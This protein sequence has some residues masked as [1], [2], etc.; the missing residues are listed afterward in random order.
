[1]LHGLLFN[2]SSPPHTILLLLSSTYFFFLPAQLSTAQQ[3]KKKKKRKK[4]FG[5]ARWMTTIHPIG[6]G[7]I[8]FK[9]SDSSFFLYF[10]FSSIAGR[11]FDWPHI[12]AQDP[13]TSRLD[14]WVATGAPRKRKNVPDV[15]MNE[16]T[17]ARVFLLGRRQFSYYKSREPFCRRC[18]GRLQ[19]KR[20]TA[21]S[22]G[23]GGGVDLRPANGLS[24]AVVV[25]C[26]AARHQNI[27]FFSFSLILDRAAAWFCG[28]PTSPR[29]PSSA[30]LW[31]S[32]SLIYSHPTSW[33][34]PRARK[35]RKRRRRRRRISFISQP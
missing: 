4:R 16:A 8:R 32:Y 24:S 15:S 1:M 23:G 20:Q 28:G 18:W 26:S 35:K 10:F 33:S 30:S 11:L 7:G 29:P 9:P 34:F 2:F 12:M 31:V 5:A 27:I 13:T 25:L 6:R 22:G 21:S 14:L 17:A 3:V 19:H